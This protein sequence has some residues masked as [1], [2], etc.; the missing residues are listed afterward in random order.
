[1]R[2]DFAYICFFLIH[3]ELKHTLPLFPL[4]LNTRFQTKT[5][6]IYTCFQTKKGVF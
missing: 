4:K 5:G 3:L 2:F 1:M 6:K